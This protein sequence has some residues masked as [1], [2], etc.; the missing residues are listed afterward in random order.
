MYFLGLSSFGSVPAY[1]PG[2]VGILL[3]IWTV[4]IQ[5]QKKLGEGLKASSLF[6]WVP[7]L[8]A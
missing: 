7:E 2:G 5:L 4:E 3:D 8:K 1:S 6:G